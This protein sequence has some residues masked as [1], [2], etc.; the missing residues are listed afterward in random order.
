[1]KNTTIEKVSP[2]QFISIMRGKGISREELETYL[3]KTVDMMLP[4]LEKEG[5]PDPYMVSLQTGGFKVVFIKDK[6]P[7]DSTEIDEKYVLLY[8]VARTFSH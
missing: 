5:Q 4:V 1:M 3:H 7:E 8:D 2:E 6:Q